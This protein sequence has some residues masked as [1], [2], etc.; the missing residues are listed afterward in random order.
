MH[1]LEGLLP[2]GAERRWVDTSAGRLSVLVAGSGGVPVVLVHGGGTDAAAISWYG[3]LPA[4]ASEGLVVAPDLP[5]FGASMD[6]D[7]VG[8]PDAMAGTAWT[9]RSCRSPGRG[10]RWS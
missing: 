3:L 2:D 8:G 6:V 4:L 9:T 10:G 5:G 7:P 1:D